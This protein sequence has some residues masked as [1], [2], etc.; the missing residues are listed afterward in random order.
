MTI[1]RLG[2]LAAHMAVNLVENVEE[3]MSGFPLNDITCWSDSSV[4]LYWLQGTE[5]YKQFVEHRVRKIQSHNSVVWRHV[6]TDSN[7]A[8]MG[9]RGNQYK[10]ELWMNGPTWLQDPES[11]P[12]NI[13]AKPSIESKVEAK[14][15]KT[16]VNAAVVQ[17]SEINETICWRNLSY[18]KRSEYTHGSIGS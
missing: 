5:T 18:R 2:L 10:Q 12:P 7:P 11:W 15:V 9:S 16:L 14:P 6:P 13:V 1:P 4:V 17:Q 3:A 8:D